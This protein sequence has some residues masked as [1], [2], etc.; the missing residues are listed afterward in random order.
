MSQAVDGQERATSRKAI[1]G[2]AL[3]VVPVLIIVVK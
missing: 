3:Y 1:D 2:I